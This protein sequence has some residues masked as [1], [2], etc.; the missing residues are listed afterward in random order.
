MNF[1]MAKSEVHSVCFSGFAATVLSRVQ[2]EAGLTET[3]T[4]WMAEKCCIL[5]IVM[6]RA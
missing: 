6:R 1:H 5:H 2:S 3:S 4:A